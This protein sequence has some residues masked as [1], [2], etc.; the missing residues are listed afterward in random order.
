MAVLHKLPQA[1]PE[2][3]PRWGLPPAP[4]KPRRRRRRLWRDQPRY[5]QP[6]Y[7]LAVRIPEPTRRILEWMTLA[8]GMPTLSD[9][10]RHIIDR[11]L[12]ELGI[13]LEPGVNAQ[14][15]PPEVDGGHQQNTG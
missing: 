9:Y 1:P 6:T 14:L 15:P 13:P 7:P 4:P 3:N 12:A 11:H 5:V 2:A 8:T 10:V